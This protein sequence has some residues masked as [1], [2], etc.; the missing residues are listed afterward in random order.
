MKLSNLFKSPASFFGK[1]QPVTHQLAADFDN[2]RVSKPKTATAG[3]NILMAKPELVLVDGQNVI[4]GSAVNPEPNLLNL[5]GLLIALH[6]RGYSFKCFF[7]S[8]TFFTLKKRALFGQAE[9]YGRLCREFPD[10]FVVTPFGTDADEYILA[11]SNCRGTQIISNDRYRDYSEKYPWVKSD[12]QR[13]IPF[14][15]HSNSIQVVH[16]GIEAVIPEELQSGVDKLRYML[17]QS[18]PTRISE[19]LKAKP[20]SMPPVIMNPARA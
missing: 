15:K 10:Q 6:R 16:L 5:L 8:P 18:K 1:S 11:Y 17:N 9:A 12:G 19:R 14:L 4:Y 13:R 3:A 20:Y 7:D 2:N